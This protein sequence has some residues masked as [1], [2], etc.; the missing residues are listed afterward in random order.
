MN[1]FDSIAANL[2]ELQHLGEEIIAD[3]QANLQPFGAELLTDT[4]RDAHLGDIACAAQRGTS[5]DDEVINTGGGE[6]ND[7]SYGFLDP[8][9]KREELVSLA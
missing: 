4:S 8:D 3:Q 9:Q 7:D 6:G 1:E 5:V 2:G